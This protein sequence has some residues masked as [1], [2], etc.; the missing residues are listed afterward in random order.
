MNRALYELKQAPMA[1]FEK[2]RSALISWGFLK[3]RLD[4]SLFVKEDKRNL[5]Y[6]LVHVDDI[7]AINSNIEQNSGL[8]ENLDSLFAL[9]ILGLVHHFL[10]IEVSRDKSSIHLC[11]TRCINDILV[12]SGLQNLKPSKTPMSTSQK[13]TKAVENFLN[14]KKSKAQLVHS[15]TL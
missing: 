15:S 2:L 13:P 11:K 6:V 14:P 12:R 5:I 1:W 10:G 4:T 8:I 9:K 3:T 7:W